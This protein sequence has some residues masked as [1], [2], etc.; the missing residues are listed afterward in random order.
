MNPYIIFFVGL[1]ILGLLFAYFAAEKHRNKKR[2]GT[3][4]TAV[5]A[6]LCGLA[7]QTEGLRSGIDL[8]GGSAFT[9]RVDPKKDDQGQPVPVSPEDQ[10]TAISVI[11]DRLD[12]DGVKDMTIQAQGDDRI[13]IE[14]PGTTEEEAKEIAAILQKQAVLNFRAV[15]SDNDTLAP[16]VAS[17]AVTRP[18]GYELLQEP[19]DDEEGK[20][21]LD[22]NGEPVTRP[23]LVERR[24]KVSGSEIK[25]AFPDYSRPGVMNIEL[26]GEGGR[27]M[28]DYTATITPGRDRMAHV[29][30]GKVLSAPG[31]Q[32]KNLG[33]KF[34]IT[35]I[36]GGTAVVE[37]LA[38]QLRNPLSNPLIIEEQRQ[39]SARLGDATIKQGIYAGVAGL[40]LTLVF[41]T[42]YYRF[43]GIIALLGL[44][45]NILILFGS[46]AMF[47][48]T[49]T[50]PG[51]AGI[52]LTIGVAVDANVLIFERLREEM[53][54]GKSIGAAIS[55]AYD[56][57]FSAI[58]DAN[59]TTLITAL[60][61]FWRASGTVK[62]FAIT[63]TIGILASMFAALL[64]TRI[65]FWWF[66]DAGM[67]KKL[68]FL[69]VVPEKTM[70]FLSKGKIAFVISSV[71][72]VGSLLM[73]GIKRE[74]AL[75]IDFTGGALTRF[76]LGD[77]ELP[78]AKVQEEV[79][80]TE[81][82]AK[83]PQVQEEQS[84][85]GFS[86]AVRSSEKDV[87]A[88]VT[89]LRASFPELGDIEYS[90]E[91][92][93]AALG[94]DFLKNSLIALGIGLFGIL[95]YIT[96]RFEFSFA[97]GAFV[98]LAHDV[99]ICIGI[100]IL[101][102]R[103]FSLIHVGAILTIAGYSINDT[104]V[105]F[106]R[107]RE[108]LQMRS[109][110]INKI[111]NEAI[112]ATLSRTILTSATTFVAVL[113][114]FIFGGAAMRDFAL[115]MMIGVV[116]G[117]YSSIFVAAPVVSW[118]SKKRGTNLRAEVIDAQLEAQVNPGKG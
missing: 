12:P 113:V 4:V 99:I 84:A 66:Q 18:A 63:L 56:K 9:V 1:L 16:Q 109:G 116:V 48:F 46:M 55:A 10:Q 50:L 79:N 21:L 70:D 39:V 103:E 85:S 57:A 61:L 14:M 62:G 42:I 90:T 28:R 47:G 94:G 102:G 88:I 76:E 17:G 87:P 80:K 26:T 49:F 5:V 11:A 92:V 67:V 101:L 58:F 69:N 77:N 72:I 59:I 118:W 89:Q 7:I 37:R 22:E 2:I 78:V 111:M 96:L 112:N 8:A 36:S 27:K 86:L 73:T 43:A 93:S 3:T 20:P 60:I 74:G 71:L 110:D 75:G 25:A 117:T 105:V 6:L 65:L 82:L 81:G 45:V 104:I 68:N 19:V 107:I 106:D 115:A 64:V 95:I 98:A 97:L 114:L 38:Q 33:S 32:S 108:Q 54:A 52:I 100:L 15:H 40:A 31:F 30:D 34:I 23:I 24:V 41:V 13:T 29:L 91:T 51:I 44:L 35:G 53:A 83:E